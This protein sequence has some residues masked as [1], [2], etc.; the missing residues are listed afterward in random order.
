MIEDSHIQISEHPVAASHQNQILPIE[1][2]TFENNGIHYGFDCRNYAVFTIDALGS[3]VLSRAR[4][5]SL[6][7][8]ITELFPK[9][10]EDLVKVRYLRIL[11][12]L[13]NGILS[14]TPVPPPPR[15]HFHRLVVMLAGGCNMAC[16]YCFEKDIPTY[17]GVNKMTRSVADQVIEWFS[18]HQKGPKAHVQL[19]GGE[20]L[21]NWPVLTH[22][23][24]QLEQ[25]ACLKQKDLSFYLITNGT[26]LDPKKIQ[27]L[28]NHNVSI[29][30]SVDGGQKI[31]DRF[32]VLKSGQ[33][34]FDLIAPNISELIDHHMD[35]NL[36]AVLT[37]FQPDPAR[38]VRELISLGAEKVSF[39]VVASDLEAV[40]LTETDWDHFNRYYRTHLKSPFKSW[41]QLPAETQRNIIN[42]CE[43]KRLS[44][45]CGAGVT[46][47]TVSPDGYLYE[48]QRLFQ[49]P[50]AHV[51]QDIAINQIDSR[52]QT[53]V[54]ARDGC[55][56]CWAR[57]LCGGGCMHQSF[58]EQGDKLPFKK[59]CQ[60]KT[61]ELEAAIVKIHE[62]KYL[63]LLSVE[64][65]NA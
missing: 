18:R 23:V 63:N 55:K 40:R 27:Y 64:H 51:S 39:E 13:R 19:Y 22:V 26:L 31:H 24:E 36:R 25:W 21:L 4:D 30:V 59:Y 28:K 53:R 6:T 41:S 50:C 8:I 46:E 60:T 42:I 48:C 34:T 57:Y 3:L 15:P 16:H 62:I 11:E 9:H 2:H 32:R 10:E 20:P 47:F 33:P 44:Y 37:R 7:A 29:Q 1:V 65:S 14:D 35:F 38:V 49:E 58:I 52:I 12:M 54:D 56:K 17:Q 45:G 61:A 5:R 43:G